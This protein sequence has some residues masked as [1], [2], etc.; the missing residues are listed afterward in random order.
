[1]KTAL[2]L[3]Y[4]IMLIFTGGIYALEGNAETL[5][6]KI[7]AA[8]NSFCL[9][10]Y[11]ELAEM[12]DN[13][14][15]S[16]LSVYIAL[17]MSAE[18]ARNQTAAEFAQLLHYPEDLMIEEDDIPY[19]IKPIHSFL[20]KT[21]DEYRSGMRMVITEK[22][23]RVPRVY[24]DSVITG[25]DLEELP[26]KSGFYKDEISVDSS[27]PVARNSALNYEL[28][29]SNALFLQ[30]GFPIHDSYIDTI[31]HYY[32]DGG[33]FEVDFIN[34]IA[35]AADQIN[36]WV[37]EQTKG[38][39]KDIFQP[40]D[41][42]KD[43]WIRLVLANTIYFLGAWKEPFKDSHTAERTFTLTTGEKIKTPIMINSDFDE[44]RYGAFNA[45]GS[46]FRTPRMLDRGQ[47]DLYPDSDG[48]AILE[49]P[50]KECGLAMLVIA[51][52]S[53]EGLPNIEEQLNQKNLSEWIERLRSRKVHVWMPKFKM[54][55]KSNL[56]KTLRTMGLELAFNQKKA[57]LSGISEIR[58]VQRLYISKVIHKAFL[59]VD[60]KGTEAAAATTVELALTSGIEIR[61]RIPFIPTF[62]ADRPFLFV[63]RDVN[64]GLI[65]FM[66]RVINPE[67]V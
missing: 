20:S 19:N 31:S 41:P 51:P 44:G 61:T 5:E 52:N 34:D 35:G 24:S 46:F 55:Y 66:G 15:F 17:T 32:T 63:I 6:N 12:D 50:Y 58:P 57:D 26:D 14:F 59:E 38:R 40:G 43:K 56:G 67:K 21:E 47:K 1:M 11:R 16:P 30:K 65:L 62:K 49:M 33:T 54:E 3:V 48:F 23:G 25:S 60:E 29:I 22:N 28:N 10:L 2:A 37:E 8:N 45:D 13:L 27:S 39:I 42:D 36:S 4:C 18:G 53:P 7:P 9:D 64:N